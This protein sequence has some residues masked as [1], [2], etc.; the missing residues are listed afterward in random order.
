MVA[1]VE[2]KAE[3][4]CAGAATGEAFGSCTAGT[5]TLTKGT[6]RLTPTLSHTIGA[7]NPRH[8]S[9]ALHLQ[10]DY[11]VGLFSLLRVNLANF[12]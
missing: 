1:E 10:F 5:N 7:H 12:S 4:T 6:D 11:L 8:D 2:L 3:Q 9:S